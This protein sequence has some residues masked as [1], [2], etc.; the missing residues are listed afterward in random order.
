M[1]QRKGQKGRLST[2]R[3]KHHVYHSSKNTA[4]PG[5]AVAGDAPPGKGMLGSA[6]SAFH[7]SGIVPPALH[8]KPVAALYGN[9]TPMKKSAGPVNPPHRPFAGGD[10]HPGRRPAVHAGIPHAKKLPAA[11]K[12]ITVRCM[13][14][15][16]LVS[17]VERTVTHS[18]TSQQNTSTAVYRAPT[19]P[20]QDVAETEY[21]AGCQDDLR[22]KL[23]RMRLQET[24]VL[25]FYS[26]ICLITSIVA[27][28]FGRHSMPP[29]VCN[30]DASKVGN[31]LSKFGHARPLGSRIIHYVHDGRT[32]TRMYRQKECL[33]APFCMVGSI[34][35]ERTK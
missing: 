34:L 15:N 30:P 1:L 18:S 33:F 4:L 3:T 17:P 5:R 7:R 32:D 28:G 31:L 29:P 6:S 14:T 12:N 27:A 23:E 21:P 8:R 26:C 10:A 35:N 13:W 2:S 24:M 11:D 20:P 22:R 25:L 9:T 16:N 19:P